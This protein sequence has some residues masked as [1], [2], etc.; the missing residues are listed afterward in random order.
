[1]L[2]SLNIDVVFFEISFKSKKNDLHVDTKGRTSFD[3]F[4]IN[5]SIIFDSSLSVYDYKMII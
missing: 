1:M 4:E 3:H 5:G 2:V